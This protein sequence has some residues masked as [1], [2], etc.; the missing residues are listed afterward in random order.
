MQAPKHPPRFLPTLT[1][2]VKPAPPVLPDSAAAESEPLSAESVSA[3]IPDVIPESGLSSLPTANDHGAAVPVDVVTQVMERL[4]P[5]LEQVVCDAVQ[6]SL[7]VRLQG[8][9]PIVLQDV[10]STVQRAVE[11]SLRALQSKSAADE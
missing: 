1:E 2:V 4:A 3:D 8:L 9:L 10:E 5:L 7:Q 6:Q 11:E